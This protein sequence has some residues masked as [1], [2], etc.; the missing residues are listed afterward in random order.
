MSRRTSTFRRAVVL[1]AALGL[2]VGAFLPS[3]ALAGK[4]GKAT[5]YDIGFESF[6]PTLG[7]A[8]N[9]DLYFSI[10]P[11]TR[12]AGWDASIAKSQDRGKTWKDVGPRLPTQHSVP[13]ET[14]DPYIYVDPGTDR[15]FTFHMSPILLCSVMTFSDDGGKSWQ[16]NPKGCSPTVVWDHQT[17]VAA[18]PRTLPTVGYPNILHQCVNAVYAAMCSTSVDGGMNWGPSVAAYENDKATTLCGAQ[19]GHLAAGPDGQVYL[20]TSRCGE[21]PMVYISDD[22]GLTWRQSVI[23][24]MDT[25]FV[26]PSV[27]VDSK[28]NLYASFIDERGFLYLATSTNNGKK[29]SKPVEIAKGY[30]A[31]MPVIA[32]GDPGKVVVAY[33][34]TNDLPKGY[35]TK[36][37]LEGNQ[38]DLAKKISWGGNLT[39]SHNA[40]SSKPSFQT[41]VATGSDPLGR[42]KICVRGTRCEYLVDFIEA[43]IGPDG[44]PYAA[45][46][47]GCIDACS[48]SATEPNKEGTGVGVMATLQTGP[49]LCSATCWR[50]KGAAQAKMKATQALLFGQTDE[51]RA[52]ARAHATLSPRLQMLQ[53]RATAS[54]LEAVR[55]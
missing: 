12:V 41:K 46:S 42:G 1:V 49:R 13:L 2:L 55:R 51:Q 52:L 43:V 35:D 29:W 36:G 4:G 6:E 39:V 28:G 21:K 38:A 5:A 32:A 3:L 40:L 8:S 22:D 37:Y 26:D 54:R 45:F 10:T 31:N 16:Y 19:H 25:P 24:D 34:A 20:P 53:E 15:V 50:Y 7:A 30:T 9:G 14:N 47:D 27:S 11:T 33:P 48:T 23:A 18:K 17:M 44:R